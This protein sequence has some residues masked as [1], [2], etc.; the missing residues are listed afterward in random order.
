MNKNEFEQK[1][2]ELL[3]K[4][5]LYPSQHTAANRFCDDFKV[6]A[7]WHADN[8]A[9]E[10][11]DLL[12]D[13]SLMVPSTKM[14]TN[15]SCNLKDLIAPSLRENA[16][17][18]SMLPTL[19]QSK[20]K[21]IGVG[22]LVFPLIINGWTF[23]TSGDGFCLGGKREVKENGASLKPVETGV[24]EKGTIDRLNKQYFQGYKPGIVKTHSKHVDYLS[25]FGVDD[26]KQIYTNYFT[27]LYP[28]NNVTSLA[29][30]ITDNYICPTH[31]NWTLGKH[32]LK[33]YK[34]IDQWHSIVVIDPV[35]LDMINVFDVD[36]LD[37]SWVKF[38]SKMDRARDT[39]AVPDG[40]VNISLAKKKA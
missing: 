21:G 34:T 14:N 7:W 30:E 6:Y 25:Q 29:E 5:Q 38:Q 2:N 15:F 28:G 39:Q 12:L 35:S 23:A 11:F 31:F 3:T 1:C 32:V 37:K 24:T 10:F 16:T 19:V 9:T 13:D 33:W 26:I 27:E 20:G 40:Y 22:E 8:D 36:D 17:F 4:R 18:S